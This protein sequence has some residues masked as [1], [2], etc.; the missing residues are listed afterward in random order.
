MSVLLCI[1]VIK[2]SQFNGVINIGFYLGG[3]DKY[4]AKILFLDKSILALA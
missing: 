3:C 1:N 2:I 4:R